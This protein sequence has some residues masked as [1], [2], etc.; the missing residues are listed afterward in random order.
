MATLKKLLHLRIFLEET[1]M[2]LRLFAKKLTYFLS[3]NGIRDE[4]LKF[5]KEIITNKIL[6]DS[7]LAL[8]CSPDH[9]DAV[10]EII[11]AVRQVYI[12][13]KVPETISLPPPED[14]NSKKIS[15]EI[16]LM[17]LKALQDNEKRMN[18]LEA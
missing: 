18:Q 9:Y 7:A 4:I 14:M 11:D 5:I 16:A 15:L 8:D 12:G 10:R 3:S 13:I 6:F 1:E 17:L 2:A